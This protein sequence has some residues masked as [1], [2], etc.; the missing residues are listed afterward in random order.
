VKASDWPQTRIGRVRQ[1]DDLRAKKLFE[2]AAWAEANALDAVS[3]TKAR[4]FG[5]TAVSAVSPWYKS[6]N[7][8][9]AARLAHQALD[10]G[11]GAGIRHRR[12]APIA[13]S[14]LE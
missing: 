8:E 12:A 14:G 9:E 7:L 10:T 3:P 13:A 2:Q 11:G 6:E 1:H 5:V 4:T